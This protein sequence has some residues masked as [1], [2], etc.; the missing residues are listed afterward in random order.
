MV[1]KHGNPVLGKPLQIVYGKGADRNLLPL[2]VI[3]GHFGAD[4]R[5]V[6]TADMEAMSEKKRQAFQAKVSE[7]SL[8]PLFTG[9][10][11]HA[12][13]IAS[14][15]D[16]GRCPRCGGAT[17]RKYANFIYATQHGLRVMY[18]PAGHFCAGCPSVI[19]EED[20]IEA[21]I[22]DKRYR[23][24]RVIGIDHGAKKAP[25]Y[26]RTWNGEDLIYLLDEDGTL[27]GVTTGSGTGAVSSVPGSPK[28]T[29]KKAN[30]KR[31]DKLAKLA[32]RRN[33]RR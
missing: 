19:I 29:Y 27:E 7:A 30:R 22:A 33:R 6:R 9:A 12:Y 4:R 5:S 16:P 26:F 31:R 18:A 28:M 11:D 3:S 2:S 23:Y 17:E 21:G 14:V 8:I 15:S 13:G 20:L 25:G 24:E 32:R 1:A 10:V